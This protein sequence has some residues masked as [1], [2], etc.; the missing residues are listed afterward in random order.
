MEENVQ[1]KSFSI[2]SGLL[3]GYI[4]IIFH[5]ILKDTVKINFEISNGNSYFLLYILK[6]GVKMFPKH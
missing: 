2:S 6:V 3:H 1:Y 5:V 4:E